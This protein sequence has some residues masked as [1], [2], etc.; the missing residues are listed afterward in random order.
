MSR[1]GR[2][3]VFVGA[4]FVG[5]ILVGTLTSLAGAQTGQ[6]ATA[7]WE[8]TTVIFGH[9]LGERLKPDSTVR[10]HGACDRLSQ[11]LLAPLYLNVRPLTQNMLA[12][13]PRCF[14]TPLNKC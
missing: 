2:G 3:A 11:N 1:L 9:N 5:T 10:L 13:V 8:L 14:H 4:I 12:K 6:G 7:D